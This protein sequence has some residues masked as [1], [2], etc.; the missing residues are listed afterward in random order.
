PPRRIIPPANPNP[1]HA[2][3]LGHAGKS[4]PPIQDDVMFESPFNLNIP[5]P[6]PI[7]GDPILDALLFGIWVAAC[8]YI[9]IYI[10]KALHLAREGIAHQLKILLALAVGWLVG[11]DIALALRWDKGVAVIS[12]I[13]GAFVTL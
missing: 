12:G 10:L 2:I 11:F 7:I 9:L 13:V 4:G 5:R 6:R 8:G 1:D 3:L